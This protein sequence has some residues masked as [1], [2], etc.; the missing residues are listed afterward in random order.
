MVRVAVLLGAGVAL[1]LPSAARAVLGPLNAVP[2]S[3]SGSAVQGSTLTCSPGSWAPSPTSYSY[4]WQ[5]DVTTPVGGNSEH[6]TLTVADVGQAITC[7][8][9][10]EDSLGSSLPA[11]SVPPIVPVALPIAAVPI[12]TSLPAISGSAVQ[13]QTVSCS[14]G[15]WEDDPSS[16]AYSWQRDGSSIAGQAASRYELAAADVDQAITC[17]VIASNSSGSGP[18]A[19]SLPILP[20]A[21]VETG[22]SNAGGGS[23]GAGGTPSGGSGSAKPGG[24]VKTRA[25][26]VMSFG[27]SPR[28]MVVTVRGRRQQTKGVTFSYRLSQAGT[29]R[30]AIQRILSGRMV[31]RRCDTH[32]PRRSKGRRCTAYG[33]GTTLTVKNAR[34]ALDRHAYSG[35]FG[36]GLLASGRYRAVIAS[37]NTG[38]HSNTRTASFTVVRKTVSVK[39]RRRQR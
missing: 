20:A 5:R 4:S 16:Y 39:S 27:V 13:G 35:R 15:A 28:K 2:P 36:R 6:Y 34:A 33:R 26:S 14:P 7:T 12:E 17:M 31:G 25:P 22:G 23:S 10:T 19:I 30:I 3:I 8:V 29:V 9:V 1:A 32:P 11:V 21:E 18:P 38:G 37:S 24:A